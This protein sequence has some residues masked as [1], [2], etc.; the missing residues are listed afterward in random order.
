MQFPT[1]KSSK[2]ES[3]SNQNWKGDSPRGP[4][5]TLGLSVAHGK[6]QLAQICGSARK[7]SN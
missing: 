4:V 5:G 3:K 2:K 6:C 1:K 7:P